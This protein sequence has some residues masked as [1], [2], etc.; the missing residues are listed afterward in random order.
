[1]VAAAHK[2][3]WSPFPNGIYTLRRCKTCRVLARNSNG[4]MKLLVCFTCKESATTWQ[5]GAAY[6]DAHEPRPGGLR[7]L[8][9]LSEAEI[10]KLEKQYG[11]PVK[12]PLKS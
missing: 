9:D 7:T 5:L 11:V 1:M 3:T 10:Q 2:H 8:K 4:N 6:C 12:R